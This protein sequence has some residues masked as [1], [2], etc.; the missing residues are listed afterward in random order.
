M[1]CNGGVKW[2]R[3]IQSGLLQCVAN[4]LWKRHRMASPQLHVYLGSY[5]DMTGQM[6]TQPG[7]RDAPG[8]PVVDKEVDEL[9]GMKFERCLVCFSCD[10][11]RLDG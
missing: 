7:T 3:G 2:S 6:A 5:I 1:E 8:S 10:L 9:Q 11:P 4:Y